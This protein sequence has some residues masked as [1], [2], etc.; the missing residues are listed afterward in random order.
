M[1]IISAIIKNGFLNSLK[2][3]KVRKTFPQCT[4]NTVRIEL[5]ADLAPN[6]AIAHDA[7]IRGNVSIGR[8]TYIEPYSFVNAAKIGS[9]CAI[10][11]NV[12]IGGFQHPYRY[13]TISPKVYRGILETEY[14]DPSHTIEIGNDVWIGEKAIVLGGKIGDGAIIA[15]GAVVTK[16]IEP[17]SIAAGVPAKKIG[18]R[19]SE[20]QKHKLLKLK[21]WNWSDEEILLHCDFFEAQEK[22]EEYY[23]NSIVK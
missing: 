23:D 10:G 6:V 17:Y 4:I 22:W 18:D 11:R 19:F 3:Y 21:W 9:F 5:G 8:W 2:L 15:A 1:K 14:K 20:K 13:P 7:E 12:A 16:D